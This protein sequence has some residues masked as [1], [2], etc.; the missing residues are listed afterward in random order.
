MIYMEPSDLGW[1]PLLKSWINTLPNVISA[2]LRN[3]I[4][5]SLFRRFCDPI[6]YWLHQDIAEVR[7]FKAFH[8]FSLFI[9]RVNTHK[10]NQV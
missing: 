9:P 4:Y 8:F 7:I 5:E 2:W 10:I 6:L 3:F 1:D